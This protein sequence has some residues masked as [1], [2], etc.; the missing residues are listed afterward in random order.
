MILSLESRGGM[1]G[2]QR[3]IVLSSDDLT[4]TQRQELE[5]LAAAALT[6]LPDIDDSSD[7]EGK[8]LVYFRLVLVND[9]GKIR[10]FELEGEVIKTDQVTKLMEMISEMGKR[11]FIAP[12]ITT[13][14]DI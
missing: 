8:D 9:Q 3:R 12:N 7:R 11:E 13:P 4:E 14:F 1:I 5:I 10:S 6:V 2:L